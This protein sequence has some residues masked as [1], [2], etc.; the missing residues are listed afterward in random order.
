MFG[1]GLGF[2]ARDTWEGGIIRQEQGH[3]DLG[4]FQS[5][6]FH[7]IDFPVIYQEWIRSES[8]FSGFHFTG[9]GKATLSSLRSGVMPAPWP[10]L[11]HSSQSVLPMGPSP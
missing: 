4:R 8:G 3:G 11:K 6:P 2:W 7:L 9:P 5:F 1:V 10:P